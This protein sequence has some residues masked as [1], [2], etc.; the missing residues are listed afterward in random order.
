VTE[1][2]KPMPKTWC[3]KTRGMKIELIRGKGGTRGQWV[4]MT[5][6]KDPE[7]TMPDGQR[8]VLTKYPPG[9]KYEWAYVAQKGT[10]G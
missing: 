7:F 9:Y 6:P 5:E 10:D 1:T 3:D 4:R 8:F 2:H